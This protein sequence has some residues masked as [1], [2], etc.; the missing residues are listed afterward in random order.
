MELGPSGVRVNALCPGSVNG[1]RIEGV[2]ERDAAERGMPSEQV[3]EMYARQSSM[4]V[5]I[6]PAD[7]AHMA[8]FIASDLGAKISGQS[9]GIDGHT[10]SLGG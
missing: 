10:E 9:I 3:R 1:Q 8:L 4:R 2:I 5:F 7:I 6:E